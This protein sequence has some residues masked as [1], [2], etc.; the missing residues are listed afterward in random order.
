V[1]TLKYDEN[2]LVQ[3]VI[4]SFG[5]C[6]GVS[7]CEGANPK[8][9]NVGRLKLFFK[10][11]GGKIFKTLCWLEC[12]QTGQVV[13]ELQRNCQPSFCRPKVSLEVKS[14]VVLVSVLWLHGRLLGLLITVCS[15]KKL[16]VSKHKTV[17][18][19]ES[20]IE[21]LNFI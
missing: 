1:K 8:C 14:L 18:L 12:R 6:L 16:A 10:M 17:N 21:K 15:Y 20:L 3:W 13:V 4:G 2:H 7:L 19:H 9:A 5:V 11:C